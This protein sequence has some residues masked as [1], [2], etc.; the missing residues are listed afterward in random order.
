L[1]HFQTI[2]NRQNNLKNSAIKEGRVDFCYFICAFLLRGLTTSQQQQ[3]QQDQQVA[4][5]RAFARPLIPHF[6]RGQVEKRTSKNCVNNNKP[7]MCI[8]KSIPQSTLAQV[9]R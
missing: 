1:S 5:K 8:L 2:F 4:I 7:A 6:V 9:L 3:C